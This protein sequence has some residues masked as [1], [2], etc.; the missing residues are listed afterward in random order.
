MKIITTS[1]NSVRT[2]DAWCEIEHVQ[3]QLVFAV[4]PTAPHFGPMSSLTGN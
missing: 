1:Y 3:F 4:N 2:I